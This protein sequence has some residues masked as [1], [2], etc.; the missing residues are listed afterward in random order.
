M[1]NQCE[2]KYIHLETKTHKE[3]RT[4][5]MPE[6]KRIDK[7]YCEKCLDEQSKYKY[8]CSWDKPEWY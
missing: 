8:E 3:N 2:H 5:G 1:T 4:F 6:W 7:F